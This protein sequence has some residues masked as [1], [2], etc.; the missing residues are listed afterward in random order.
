MKT[1]MAISTLTAVFTATLTS[2]QAL[3]WDDYYPRH[4]Y[5]HHDNSHHHDNSDAA[6]ALV[7]GLVLGAALASSTSHS[8]QHSTTYYSNYPA[9]FTS[10]TTHYSTEP[11]YSEPYYSEPYYSERVYV[12]EP[13]THTTTYY[14]APST[15][16]TTETHYYPRRKSV[17]RVNYQD[18][19]RDE[20]G[21]CY[22]VSY[23]NGKKTLTEVARYQCGR[24]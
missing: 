18:V 20:N 7:G 5:S 16:Y 15:H 8:S 3:G 12:S 6:V 13:V 17:E 19:I 4:N 9:R 22:R 14:S 21:D 24:D 1:F 10:T 23:R 11:Y 2:G